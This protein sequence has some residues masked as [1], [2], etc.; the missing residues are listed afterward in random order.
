MALTI[1]QLSNAIRT[2][3][4]N[5]TAAAEALGITRWALQ[6]RIIKSVELQQLVKEQ[7][8][9]LVDMAESAA[10]KKIKEGDTAMIIFTLKTQGK[11]RG[12]REGPTGDENDPIH[13]RLD[14]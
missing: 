5:V 7:R 1:E 8:E 4:G 3:A 13:I 6:K 12:W 9:A 2:Q 11:E 14:K 10:R